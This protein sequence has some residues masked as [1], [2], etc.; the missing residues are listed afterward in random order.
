MPR[1]L[2]DQER[3]WRTMLE[4]ELQE[5]L[6]E[7]A[8][9]LGWLFQAVR[10]NVPVMTRRGIRHR[11]TIQGD[12]GG[13]DCLL[14]RWPEVILWELKRELADLREEQTRWAHE[15]RPGSWVEYRVVRPSDEEWCVDRLSQP[16]GEPRAAA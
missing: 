1:R 10:P 2:T 15:L 3:L 5:Q 13:P 14:V 12:V 6:R 9:R 4:K 16:S 8:R 11:T 7:H